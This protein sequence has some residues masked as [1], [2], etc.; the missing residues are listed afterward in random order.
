[1]WTNDAIDWGPCFSYDKFIRLNIFTKKS[2][3]VSPMFNVIYS[4]SFFMIP[5]A[6][7]ILWGIVA[8]R[9]GRLAY[10]PTKSKLQRS[11]RRVRI[12]FIIAQILILLKIVLVILSSTFGWLFVDDQ[13]MI[14]LPLLLSSAIATFVYT[15]PQLQRLA[16]EKIANTEANTN[17]VDRRLVSSPKFIIPV[18]ATFLST[19]IN[20]YFTSFHYTFTLNLLNSFLLWMSFVIVI[21]ALWL[22]Q[23]RSF[24]KLGQ[25]EAKIKSGF[26]LRLYRVIPLTL[27]VLV[28]FSSWFFYSSN[29]S[30]IPSE[31]S[32]M[33]HNEMDWGGP[34][35]TVA[36]EHNHHATPASKTVSITELTGPKNEK[37][38][39]R[40][41]LVAK[42]AKIRLSSGKIIEA[43]TFNGQSPGPELKVQQGDLIEVT[44]KNQDVSAGV[45]IHWHGYNVPNAEDGVAGLTQNVVK[46]GGTHVYRFRANQVGTYW[47]HSHQQSSI[48]VLKGLFGLLVVHPKK[49]TEKQVKDISVLDHSWEITKGTDRIQ[50][51]GTSDTLSK[52]VIQPG[53]PVRIRLVNTGD[54]SRYYQLSGT[55]F[56][57]VSIDG[58]EVNNPTN[59]SD[60]QL[61]LGGG[62]RYDVTFFMP[63]TPVKLTSQDKGGNLKVEKVF[64][65]NQKANKVPSPKTENP[66]FY[67]TNYGDPKAT[68][69]NK[70][71]KFDRQF[72][73]TL[74]NRFGFFDGEFYPQ[75]FT[76]NN[77]IFPNTPMLM[78]REGDL[79]KTTFINEGGADHP[80]HLHGHHMMV[81]S[82]NGKPVTGSPWWT[83]TLNVGAGETY[84]VGFRADNPGIW[85]DH[86]HNLT[87]AAVGMTMHLS[88]DGVT[89]PYK[90]GKATSNLPE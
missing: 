18:Q 15:F 52:Q 38:D 80:M 45:T 42:K 69:F 10:R 70:S 46:P 8:N 57:V 49:D 67:P 27:A 54:E 40:F 11:I 39:R 6:L 59:L 64:S 85:M 30:R 87:H 7:I 68:S 21:T 53:T 23:Q 24:R 63:Q 77:K 71:S 90:A 88:Y 72:T 16:R 28:G 56:K 79:V 66:I 4:L 31:Y 5:L 34:A 74:N 89:T 61:L 78:V 50:A 75:I 35:P 37:P 58:N 9:L 36:P 14:V 26:F 62:G 33:D 1:L 55:H 86:C 12:I 83:D 17:G 43:W 51:F 13:V 76:I 48:Q 82:Q 81:L 22:R 65:G 60:Q 73:F 84:E 19:I 3:G 20:F 32:M 41:T 29:A 44:L 25:E 2:K 47:Y